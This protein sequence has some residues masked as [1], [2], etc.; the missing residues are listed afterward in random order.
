LVH[1]VIECELN[2][3]L[4]VKRWEATARRH[5]PSKKLV[6]AVWPVLPRHACARDAL[7]TALCRKNFGC[8]HFIAV[9]D[10]AR[11]NGYALDAVPRLFDQFDDL[12]IALLMHDEVAREETTSHF[13]SHEKVPA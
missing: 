12:G 5:L 3:A 6:F 7:F 13:F 11:V 1:P 10:D 8:S 9:G 4:I 2:A